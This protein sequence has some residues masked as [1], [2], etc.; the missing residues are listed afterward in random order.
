M[1]RALSIAVVG[2][3]LVML[4]LLVR[5]TW[6]T[7]PPRPSAPAKLEPGERDEWMSVYR[8]EQ[9]IGYSHYHSVPEGERVALTEESLLRVAML[10]TEQTV[11][12]R[13]RAHVGSDY[14]LQDVEFDLSSGAGNMRAVGVVEGTGLRLTLHTGQDD[15]EQV[16]PLNGPVY[17]PSVL[18]ALL[19][20]HAL[21]PGYRFEALIFDPISFSNGRMS[22]T[23]E[24]EEEVPHRPAMRAWRV[25]EEF[26]G[27]TTTAWIDAGGASL[28]EEGPMGFVLVRATADQAL[29]ADWTEGTALDLVASAA[30]P[31]GRPI[32]DARTRASLHL[33]VSGIAPEQVPSD[34]EQIRRGAEVTI[35]R[36]TLG[37]LHSYQLPYSGREHAEEV[38]ATAFLQS[39]HPRIQAAAQAAVGEER[40]AMRAAIRINDWVYDRLRKVPTVSIP[41]ALQVLDMGAGD[42]NEHAVL[43]AALARAAG[44]P[45]RTIA[46]A[47]YVDGAF[48]Y[49]AWCEIWLGRWVSIDPALHQ[50]PVDA[51][52]IKFI[53]GG[54][55]EQMGMLAII[56]RLGLDVIDD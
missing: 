4:G 54:P 18:A 36:A 8:G 42:C 17:V 45:A 34:E 44:L 9:K 38:R 7:L 43:F 32:A 22:V 52:H 11:R 47:V 1:K 14:R 24:Q 23:V 25:R 16:L 29:N 55:D 5:N 37:E 2:F 13:L 27:V 33:R 53:V 49:H 6:R 26:R 15:S 35:T 41:N 3:W 28:R 50:F 39:E 10:E 46:G 19:T 20:T 51:T 30:V 31:V 56:G 12:V 21:R 48:L 40:D